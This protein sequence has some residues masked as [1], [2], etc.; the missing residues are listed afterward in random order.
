MEVQI[1]IRQLSVTE[2]Q[3]IW[4]L[5]QFAMR[6]HERGI[7]QTGFM[8]S[9]KPNLR[10]DFELCENSAILSKQCQNIGTIMSR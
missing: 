7:S 10:S 3:M 4:V 2:L 5:E 6:M 1:L 9:W 8:S